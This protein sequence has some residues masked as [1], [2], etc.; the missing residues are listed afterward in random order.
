[1]PVDPVITSIA[2]PAGWEGQVVV[3]EGEGFGPKQVVTQVLF[4]GVPAGRAL[5]WSE[6]LIEVAVPQGA[7]T[8][9]ICIRSGP[10]ESNRLPFIVSQPPLEVV[11][12]VRT[13]FLGDGHWVRHIGVGDFNEDGRED[14]ALAIGAIVVLFS[15][16][17][18]M[19]DAR[20]DYLVDNN[21]SDVIV[22][23]FNDDGHLDI[24]GG[25]GEEEDIDLLFGDGEG[26]FGEPIT[27]PAPTAVHS[28]TAADFDE[29]GFLDIIAPFGVMSTTVAVLFGDG[30]GGFGSPLEFHVGFQPHGVTVGDYNGDNHMDAAITNSGYTIGLEDTVSIVFG[31]GQGG[32]S[33]DVEYAVGDTPWDIVSADLNGDG[34]LDL[35]VANYDSSFA[36]VLL[37]DGQGGFADHLPHPLNSADAVVA[38]DYNGDGIPDL[39]F[40]ASGGANI[41]LGYGDGT[42]L[43][44]E[45]IMDCCQRE[46]IAQGDFDGNGILDLAIANGWTYNVA[47]LT[48]DGGGGFGHVEA[49]DG[50]GD[51]EGI[52]TGDFNEDGH[53]DIAAAHGVHA[54]IFFGDGEGKF[55][56]PVSFLEGLGCNCL[57]A[58]DWDRDGHLDL[59]VVR[60]YYLTIMLGDGQ[61]GFSEPLDYDLGSIYHFRNCI[62]AADYNEDGIMDLVVS[63]ESPAIISLF[64]GDGTGEF[65]DRVDYDAGD[66]PTS[67]S[68]GDFDEDGFTDLAVADDDEFVR[69]FL[70]DGQ[71]GLTEHTSYESHGAWVI[72]EDIDLDG[73]LDLL[74]TVLIMLDHYY[75]QYFQ[76]FMGN[77]DGTFEEGAYYFGGGSGLALNDF[78]EDG[79]PDVAGVDGYLDMLYLSL[80]DGLGGFDHQGDYMAAG[81]PL[82]AASADFNEDGHADVAVGNDGTFISIFLGDGLGGFV[83]F[84]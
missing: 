74:L 8:G 82:V 56:A 5:S 61:G 78:N 42:F 30:Q 13:Y 75:D 27:S 72:T 12:V 71:G 10:I 35:A 2:P 44:G 19:W 63:L 54:N 24:V 67:I 20:M 46:D 6:T 80:G 9:E 29:D 7:P 48:G 57:T 79:L 32:F 28:M 64:L 34:A 43:T 83:D 37:N 45:V 22:G 16:E 62:D 39:A 58:G 81:K 66:W 17:D 50:I 73:H 53:A 18:G 47:L 40:T 33:E 31:D 26:G 51:I 11:P 84:N 36:S 23:D 49:Y 52:V 68:S 70:G 55:S 25:G 4:S 38:G 60:A 69:I 41:L 65:P 59:A 1:M 77:G 15:G 21:C 3:I 14:V 76:V